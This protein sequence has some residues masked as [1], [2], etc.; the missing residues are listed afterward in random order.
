MSSVIV[1]GSSR[2]DNVVP[3]PGS[4][5]N[6]DLA[7]IYLARHAE[8]TRPVKKFI[9]SFERHSPGIEHDCV[10]IR[11]GF[12]P[13]EPGLDRLLKRAFPN[14]ISVSDGGFD[15]SAYAKAAA[16]LPHKHVV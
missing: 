2:K 4:R 5:F 10:V 8:G 15:I 9:E 6:T 16:Q 13:G 11:K 7:V 12:P 1:G 3:A 14:F